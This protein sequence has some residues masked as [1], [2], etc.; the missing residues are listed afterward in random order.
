VLPLDITE[1]V[2][3][4]GATTTDA[5]IPLSIDPNVDNFAGG[6]QI[7]MASTLL[8]EI[9]VPA[10]ECFLFE[11][12][13]FSEPLSSRL[14]VA[15]DMQ[16]L[17]KK[18][19][20]TLTGIDPVAEA[21]D[22]VAQ[23]AK[24]Q[25]Q[26]GGFAWWPGQF[27]SD[28]YLTGY[29]AQALGRM[30]QAGLNTEPVMVTSV[31]A[32]LAARLDNPDPHGWCFGYDPCIERMRFEAMLGLAA[33]GDLSDKRVADVYA[34]RNAFDLVTQIELARF[35]TA[36]PAWKP[37]ADAMAL[38]IQEL[39]YETGRYA[40]LNTPED[41]W[42]YDSITKGQ[43][44][45]VRLYVA[46]KYDTAIIDRMVR[47]LL[48]LRRKGSWANTYD[49]AQ[50]LNALIDYAQL[51]PEPPA[52]T[53]TANLNGV[54]IAN[55]TF[56]GYQ[57]SVRDT[58]VATADLPRGASDLRLRKGGSGTLH[59]VVS[60]TYRLH[61]PQPGAEAGLLIS[62]DVRPV[63]KDDAVAHMGLGKPLT[64]TTLPAAQVYDVG[65]TI[66]VDHPVNQVI[67]VDPLPAGME[68]VDTTFNTTPRSQTAT[69]GDWQIDYQVIHHDRVVAFANYLAPGIYTMHYLSRTVTP[70]TYEWPGSQ[71]FLEYAPEEFGRSASTTLTIP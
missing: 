65:L 45:T 58:F 31:H 4:T 64:A 54:Q 53:A 49:D 1:S 66:I 50:A 8:P 42:W 28:P 29:A 35:M 15:A 21:A 26:D 44:E 2:V 5:T 36:L 57:D 52:F 7:T 25:R 43:A 63:G 14:M 48:A 47:S 19:G 18:Y 55:N 32:Y 27:D 10:R 30:Q 59:Y 34:E 13:P 69:Y 60:Y 37:Q 40:V 62:R 56:S 70:G 9:L 39:V 46:Q 12:L 23:L 11:Y 17:G 20:Q 67:I 6:L 51:E 16:I 68:A 22:D 3:E 33:L 41:M 24:L 71:A 38:K 61:G